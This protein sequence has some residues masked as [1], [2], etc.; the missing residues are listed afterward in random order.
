MLGSWVAKLRLAFRAFR[1]T[2]HGDRKHR[3][4]QGYTASFSLLSFSLAQA[5]FPHHNRLTRWV[6]EQTPLKTT[7]SSTTANGP[8]PGT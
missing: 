2:S 3:N 8:N 1:V 4:P 6:D 7:P 5:G